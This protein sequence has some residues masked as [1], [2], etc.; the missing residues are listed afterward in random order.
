MTAQREPE[1]SML[2]SGEKI[3]DRESAISSKNKSSELLG[4]E[5]LSHPS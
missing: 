3:H 2:P 4:D 1:V 5:D